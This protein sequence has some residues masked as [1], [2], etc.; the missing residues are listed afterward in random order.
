VGYLLPLCRPSLDPIG[1]QRRSGP[2]LG[3]HGFIVEWREGQGRQEEEEEVGFSRIVL[4][5][6]GQASADHRVLPSWAPS[7]AI[8]VVRLNLS[9][10][11]GTLSTK[12]HRRYERIG[13]SSPLLFHYA[14]PRWDWALNSMGLCIGSKLSGDTTRTP[15]RTCT[16]ISSPGVHPCP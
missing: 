9:I 11:L 2:L 6:Q 10:H 3:K 7:Q 5:C 4:P 8:S 15:S 14:L 13:S 12:G 1:L 16:S